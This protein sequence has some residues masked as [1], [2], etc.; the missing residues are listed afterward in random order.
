VVSNWSRSKTWASQLS[1]GPR[2]FCVS[3]IV[4]GRTAKLTCVESDDKMTDGSPRAIM[5][6]RPAFNFSIG[7]TRVA[8]LD[9]DYILNQVARLVDHPVAGLSFLG[10]PFG[11]GRSFASSHVLTELY[12]ADN[13][14]FR[15]K[16]EKLAS[17]S[18]GRG[19]STKPADYRRA[20]EE[21]FL[22]AITFVDVTGMF[23]DANATEA[24]HRID[25]HDAPTG[26]LAVLLSRTWP[27]VYSHDHSL[28]RPSLAPAPANFQAVL[29]AAREADSSEDLTQGFTYVAGGVL[30]AVDGAARGVAGIL[31][32]PS[33]LP[34][35]AIAGAIG[36]YLLGQDRRERLIDSL[37]PIGRVIQAQMEKYTAGVITR[38]CGCSIR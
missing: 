27:I 26:Q 12:R 3:V 15:N 8:I 25:P 33:W 24:V 11:S 38:C 32:V 22:P 18:A 4:H 14:G 29:I 7:T 6:A 36:W 17:Q 16:W 13:L 23:E 20:F 5:P 1:G 10:P 21:R 19:G 35:L 30:W 37:R 9:S 31:K 34:W 2:C 28:W